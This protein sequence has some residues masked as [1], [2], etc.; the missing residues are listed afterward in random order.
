MRVAHL[1][2]VLKV[3]GGVRG[4]Q[5]VAVRGEVFEQLGE[6]ATRVVAGPQVDD[7]VIDTQVELRVLLSTHG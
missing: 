3:V 5:Q 1:D 7:V 4:G 6:R 2:L